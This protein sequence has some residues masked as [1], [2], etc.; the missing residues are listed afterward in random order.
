MVNRGL[1]DL[2][3]FCF[4]CKHTEVSKTA[5]EEI[6][7]DFKKVVK[8]KIYEKSEPG[9]ELGLYVT[10]W[11]PAVVTDVSVHGKGNTWRLW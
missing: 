7:P 10:W 6:Q 3:P 5:L 9:H 4:T 8:K 11:A 2:R 1:T